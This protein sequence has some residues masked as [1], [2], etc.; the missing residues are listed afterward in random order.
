MAPQLSF[1]QSTLYFFEVKD[2]I[3][4][5]NSTMKRLF[6][7]KYTVYAMKRNAINLNIYVFH[8]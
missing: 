3:K 1:A 4:I 8:V 6:L 2:V 7:R 5:Y